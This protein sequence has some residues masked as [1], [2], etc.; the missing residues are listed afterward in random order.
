MEKI[1]TKDDPITRRVL[2]AAIEVHTELGPG[3]LGRP[4]LTA[5]AIALKDAGM[6]FEVEKRFPA[7]F[8]GRQIGG[9]RPD[10]IVEGYAVVEFQPPAPH[11]WRQES[12]Q[13]MRDVRFPSN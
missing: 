11:R 8:R 3:L 5:L 10:L 12:H 6:K 2:E 9:Y 13:V 1:E 7:V 4:Y